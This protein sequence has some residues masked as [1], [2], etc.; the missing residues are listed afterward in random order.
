VAFELRSLTTL[1]LV[2]NVVGEVGRTLNRK[3]QTRH[4]AVSWRKHG[5][6]VLSTIQTLFK[7]SCIGAFVLGLLE[8]IWYRGLCP[9]AFLSNGFCPEGSFPLEQIAEIVLKKT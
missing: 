1:K 6:L 5:F 2:V 9:G 4:R 8:Q 7:L 3:E